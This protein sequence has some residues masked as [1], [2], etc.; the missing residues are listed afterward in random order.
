LNCHAPAAGGAPGRAPKAERQKGFAAL[1]WSKGCVANDEASRGK[2][3]AFAL[4]DAQRGALVAFAASGREDSLWSD[5]PVEYAARA[6]RRLQ[7]T[8]CHSRDEVED[9]WSNVADE[10]GDLLPPETNVETD[11]PD[12]AAAKGPRLFVPRGLGALRKGDEIM[13]SGDQTRPTL[14]WVGEKLR[15]GYMTKII[16]GEL[17]Y[18]PR[19]WLRARMPSFAGHDVKVLAAGLANEQGFPAADEAQAQAKADAGQ[20]VG[21]KLIGRDGGFACVTCHSV[22]DTK[23]ISP[24]EAPAPNFAHVTE[25]LNHDYYL[26]WMR[27]PMRFQPGTKMPQFSEEGRSTLKEILEGDA[28]KQFEAIWDYLLSGAKVTSP[29]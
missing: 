13:I 8:A 7:C 12:A 18:K 28:D 23:A 10:V 27:K 15:F 11:Q 14:T 6:I 4:T 2:A 29:E 9:R 22:G 24:F 16:A 1:D 20:P 17:Q 19:Y 26:R 25:R 21:Q 5:V 3:P